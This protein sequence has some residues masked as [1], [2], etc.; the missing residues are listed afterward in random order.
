MILP[1]KKIHV[2]A[3]KVE[4]TQHHSPDFRNKSLLKQSCWEIES[5]QKDQ[6]S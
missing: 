6:I 2:Q 4:L 1:I 3:G 5:E